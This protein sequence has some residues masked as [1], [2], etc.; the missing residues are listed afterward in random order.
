M[1][2]WSTPD[3]VASVR[4][5]SSRLTFL[6]HRCRSS[7]LLVRALP[8]SRPGGVVLVLSF[9]G[10]VRRQDLPLA[11]VWRPRHKPKRRFE[12]R[13]VLQSWVGVE[14]VFGDRKSVV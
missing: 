9:W 12:G 4:G 2:I 13:S 5:I 3:S 11:R 6:F 8:S 7:F 10:V 1:G 14:R